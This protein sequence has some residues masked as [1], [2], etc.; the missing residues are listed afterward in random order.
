MSSGKVVLCLLAGAGNIDIGVVVH[1]VALAQ[2]LDDVEVVAGRLSNAVLQE[3][4]VRLRVR[5]S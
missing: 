1:L 5:I 4:A 3:P 2:V